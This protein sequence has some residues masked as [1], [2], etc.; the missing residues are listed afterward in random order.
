VAGSDAPLLPGTTF[1]IEPGIYL[2][3]RTGVRI[4]DDMLITTDGARSLTTLPRE[5]Q[6][7]AVEF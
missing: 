4:E 1:T 6:V 5:L 2:P 3:G 7:V